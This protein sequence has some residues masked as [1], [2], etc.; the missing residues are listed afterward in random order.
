[1]NSSFQGQEQLKLIRQFHKK[2]YY[3]SLFFCTS[4]EIVYGTLNSMN[5]GPVFQ[6]MTQ[7]QQ[8]SIAILATEVLP[9]FLNSKLGQTL[10]LRVRQREMMGQQGA[11]RTVA[12]GLDK[13]SE[14]YWFDMFRVMSETISIGV[15]ISDMTIP[16]I[17][18]IYINEGF[19]TVTG[20]GK[21]KISCG[22]RFL[23]VHDCHEIRAAYIFIF[24][25]LLLTH[26]RTH[27]F[28]P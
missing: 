7:K 9:K 24:K 17:P 22:C 25:I 23:Q 18:L 3:N 8:V 5:W 6:E 16:G 15:V 27:T 21:E 19:R 1:M 28:K 11:L 10:V 12:A 26:S 2:K 14:T 4:T 13:N 20:Y